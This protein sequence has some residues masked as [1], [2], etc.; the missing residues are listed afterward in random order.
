MAS[1]LRE[2][3]ARAADFVLDPVPAKSVETDRTG[4]RTEVVVLG[5]SPG[6]GTTTV[7]RG[8]ALALQV[9][10]ESPSL[11]LVP[12][13]FGS[14]AAS[15]ES[16]SSIVWDAGGN[17]AALPPV[18]AHRA[19]ALVLVAGKSSEPALAEITADMLREDFARV[20][21]VANRVT[22]PARWANRPAVCV[23]ESWFGA[24][25]LRRGRR[26]P[27]ALGEALVQLAIVLRES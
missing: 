6:C 20:V 3:F 21:L 5:L 19:D 1:F 26:P 18:V 8:L 9:P 2:A 15:G 11:Q 25:L 22:D 23:P 24:A 10:G 17:R 7:A 12:A 27:G 14:D 4:S 16:G 13:D